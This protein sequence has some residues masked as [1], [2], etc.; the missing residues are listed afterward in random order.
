[1]KNVE[2]SVSGDTLIVRINLK[3]PRTAS[4]SGKSDVIAST[5]GNVSVPGFPEIKLGL[6]CYTKAAGK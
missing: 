4:Q 3:A 5:E 6:N 2:T 1:M